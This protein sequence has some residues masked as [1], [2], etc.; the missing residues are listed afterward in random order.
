MS[1]VKTFEELS[2]RLKRHFEQNRAVF[3]K[4][5]VNFAGEKLTLNEEE[6]FALYIAS[7][8]GNLGAIG[9]KRDENLKKIDG[10][11]S[12]LW[13]WHL[14]TARLKQKPRTIPIEFI[15]DASPVLGCN[16][17]ATL[18]YILLN[19]NGF[20]S[21]HVGTNGHIHVETL[22]PN[23]SNNPNSRRER[24]WILDPFMGVASQTTVEAF[25]GY[26]DIPHEIMWLPNRSRE[27]AN[28]NCHRPFREKLTQNFLDARFKSSRKLI[29]Y[30]NWDTFSDF[31][32]HNGYRMLR[33]IDRK[34]IIS[35]KDYEQ[36][37]ALGTLPRQWR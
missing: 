27:D 1:D 6:H 15:W 25:Y 7:S 8:I 32:H 17:T 22:I 5:F 18:T 2:D 31:M 23:G 10:P 14:Q 26:E 3:H 16:D 24:P 19:L 4:I 34:I 28:C 11:R 30:E 33:S 37:I 36:G 9:R 35:R 20:K 21:R 29:Y 12:I 13:S